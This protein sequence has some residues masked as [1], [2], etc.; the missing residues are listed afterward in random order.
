MEIHLKR[1]T[2]NQNLKDTQYVLYRAI[3]ETLQK[4]KKYVHC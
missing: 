1:Q 2:A 4:Q 3:R